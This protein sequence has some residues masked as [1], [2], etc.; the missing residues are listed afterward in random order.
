MALKEITVTADVRVLVEI[1]QDNKRLLVQIKAGEVSVISDKCRHRGGPI[2]LCYVGADNSRRC[3]W[4]D[5][6]ILSDDLCDEVSAIY[7]RQRKVLLLVADL[8][9]G[10]PWPVRV[11]APISPDTPQAFA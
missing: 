8:P 11:I 6:K 10:V 5:K 4:H 1:P 3:I 7:Y 9:D 2:H